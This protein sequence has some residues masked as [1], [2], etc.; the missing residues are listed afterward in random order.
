MRYIIDFI[1]SISDE[2]IAAYMVRNDCTVVINYDNFSKTYLVE[3]AT[4][5]EVDAFVET[6]LEDSSAPLKLLSIPS[7][8]FPVDEDDNW[9]KLVAIDGIDTTQPT[10]TI[11]RSGG[12]VRVYVMDSGIAADHPEFVGKNITLL[13]SITPGD[14]S[15]TTGHGTSLASVI[16]GETCGITESAL[17]VV[18]IFHSGQDT[19]LSDIISAFDAVATDYLLADDFLAVLNLSW[20]IEK[21]AYI[22]QKILDLIT[23]GV[24][25][26]ASAGN[27]GRPLS[28]VTPA[29]LAEVITVGSFGKDLMPSDF[30]NYTSS[31]SDTSFTS[32][33]NN[34][35]ALDCF[36][37]GEFIRVALP[38]GGYG[39]SMGTS[40]SAAIISAIMALRITSS[41]TNW[42]RT[43]INEISIQAFLQTIATKDLLTLSG[44]YANSINLVPYVELADMTTIRVRAMRTFPVRPGI[45]IELWLFNPE[46][47]TNAAL[48]DAPSW[49]QLKG[50]YLEISAPDIETTVFEFQLTGEQDGE[51]Q[52]LPVFVI[53]RSSSETDEESYEKVKILFASNGASAK[54]IADCSPQTWCCQCCTGD[55]K[56][57]T[58]DACGI[59]NNTEC[60]LLA[61]S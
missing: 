52:S 33:Q 17:R 50:N 53:T 23:M 2:D 57:E 8:T 41:G 28:E 49:V 44:N 39:V 24:V 51:T 20:S 47:F 37:P 16:V 5:P 46:F 9:W 1:N 42:T 60:A 55:V 59:C 10:A 58:D 30:S 4:A 22:E 18:K 43:G 45:V 38:A 21:N 48:I 14:F 11:A 12:G 40:L 56:T 6:V 25:V 26:V 36:A 54:C 19:F 34:Y 13:H 31:D 35:G 32:G 3:A 15:D 27:E 29:S 7:K 61:C